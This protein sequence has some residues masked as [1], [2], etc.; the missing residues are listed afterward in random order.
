M[1]FGRLTIAH[2]DA[3]R[4]V[5]AFAREDLA[6]VVYDLAGDEARRTGRLD[7][8]GPWTLL[9][10]N[11]LAAPVG[12]DA[13][14]SVMPRLEELADLISQIPQGQDLDQLD[15][16]GLRAVG[17]AACFGVPH[18]WAAIISKVVHL[19]RPRAMPILDEK[20]A[21]AFGHRGDRFATVARTRKREPTREEV[22]HETVRQ[23]AQQIANQ[24]NEIDDAKKEAEHWVPDLGRASRA[25]FV[26]MLV[27]TTQDG[28]D[29]GQREWW[30]RG[31]PSAPIPQVDVAWHEIR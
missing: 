19:Y 29:R 23:L 10:A 3:V 13:L 20:V 4:Q 22:I 15:D 8:V 30:L 21:E 24:R 26:D 11:A 6:F 1:R 5:V 18:A 17:E 7:E 27:W 28:I 14:K 12:L 2:D 9:L 25:R 31:L 16:E